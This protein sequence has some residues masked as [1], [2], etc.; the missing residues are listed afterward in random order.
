VQAVIC[1]LKVLDSGAQACHWR[2]RCC[3]SRPCHSTGWPWNAGPLS[4][5]RALFHPLWNARCGYSDDKARGAV[6][7]AV[8]IITHWNTR[9]YHGAARV[10]GIYVKLDTGPDPIRI[11]RLDARTQSIDGTAFSWAPFDLALN[12]ASTIHAAQGKTIHGTVYIDLG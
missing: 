6:N 12:Y 9:V 5:T 7:G 3:A 4:E 11:G 2:Q 8:G 1:L 10:T